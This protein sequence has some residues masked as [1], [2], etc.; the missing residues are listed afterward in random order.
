GASGSGKTTFLEDV[1]KAHKCTYIRQ[2]HNL[3]PFIPVK[4]IP[5]FDPSALP[6]WS[7]YEK[8]NPNVAIGG[9][10]AGQFNPGFSGGQRKMLLFELIYQRTKNMNDLLLCLDEPFAGVTDD[11]VPYLKGRLEDMAKRHNVLLVT[12]DHVDAMRK[13]A[14]NTIV[15]SAIDR[16]TV[17][18]NETAKVDRT[19]ALNAVSNGNDYVHENSSA[20]LKFF[21]EVEV[22]SLAG[23]LGAVAGFTAFAMLMIILSFWDSQQGSEA[24]VLVGV[25]IVAFFCINPYL[26]SL[27]DWRTYM[28]EEAEALLHASVP[29]NKALKSTLTLI[30][31]LCISVIAFG[32]LN[33]CID[34][35]G[36]AKYFVHMLFDS[37]SLTF[38]FICVGLYTELPLQIVQIIASMP[39][40]F[41]IFFSTT[42]S[43]GAGVEAVKELRYLFARFYFWCDL[44]G[45]K[46]LM[47][48]CPA[49]NLLI[50]Y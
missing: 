25:Q 22:F 14:K 29:A 27:A 39:F 17:T 18:I 21:F 1:H 47:E 24:L 7:I 43:P 48:D 15:V 35:M 40:L 36:D 31:L 12:N 19:L 41:M 33:L 50:T 34:T 16:S 26:I 20:D 32:V 45:F 28:T 49:D 6:F 5:N 11:F 10:M 2:Y 13:L 37:A 8:E 30:V 46:D 9:T 38:P 44:P 23:G 42:F 3:R 4:K